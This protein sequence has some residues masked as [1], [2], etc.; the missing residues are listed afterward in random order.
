MSSLPKSL[1]DGLEFLIKLV[2]PTIIH[3]E[4]KI[5]YQV[6]SVKIEQ[7][8]RFVEEEAKLYKSIQILTMKIKQE[9]GEGSRKVGTNF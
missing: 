8:K 3:L 5:K 1:E 9:K 6:P 4:N 2:I 7:G